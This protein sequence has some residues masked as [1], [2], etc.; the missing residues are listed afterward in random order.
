VRSV[1]LLLRNQL[2]EGG[3]ATAV[4]SEQPPRSPTSPPVRVL[5][6][7]IATGTLQN[8][9]IATPLA[10]LETFYWAKAR[11]DFPTLESMIIVTPGAR[12]KAEAR[13]AGLSADARARMPEAAT[14][15]RMAIAQSWAGER[16]SHV[17]VDLESELDPDRIYFSGRRVHA[18]GG[19][20]FDLVLRKTASGWKWFMSDAIPSAAPAAKTR[21]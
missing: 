14:P 13:I 17:Q 16:D 20:N 21:S 4:K 1:E 8:R 12:A 6:E 10:A 9:G 2:R 19:G 7:M 15:E 11:R 5:R 18:L 3:A